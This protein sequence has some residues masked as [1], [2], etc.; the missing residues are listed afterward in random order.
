LLFYLSIIVNPAGA[1]SKQPPTVLQRLSGPVKKTQFFNL[2]KKKMAMSMSSAYG[3]VQGK[4][5]RVQAR[6][7]TLSFLFL[8]FFSF[9]FSF[10]FSSSLPCTI[11]CEAAKTFA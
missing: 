4:P 5:P 11:S 7:I 10:F 6:Q 9:L 2:L 1:V 8:S 3:Y